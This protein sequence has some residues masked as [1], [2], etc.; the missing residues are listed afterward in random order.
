MKLEVDAAFVIS[1]ARRPERLEAFLGRVPQ[2]WTLPPLELFA[3]VDGTAEQRPAWWR[4]TPGAWGCYRS[5]VA[6]IECCLDRGTDRVVIFEDDATFSRDFTT[7]VQT[8]DVPADCQQLYLGGQHLSHPKRGPPGFMV[9]TNVN[10][11]HAYALIGRPTLELVREHLQPDPKRWKAK[12]HIDHH[13]GILHREQR[14]AVY[15]VQPWICGQAAGQSDVGKSQV[16]ERW[17]TL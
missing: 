10:R 13:Y 11:T 9:G 8:L 2:P 5:H 15:A 4:S 6:I 17:W 7:C 1:L 3:A 16:K 12:H 14:I